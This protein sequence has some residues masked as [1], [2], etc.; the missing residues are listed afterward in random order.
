MVCSSRA[1]AYYTYSPYLMLTV[2][3]GPPTTA[4][5]GAP[6]RRPRP[7]G[8][9]PDAHSQVPETSDADLPPGPGGREAGIGLVATVGPDAG[10]RRDG[11]RTPPR[12]GDQP[13]AGAARSPSGRRRPALGSP[14]R[15][16]RGDPRQRPHRP[17]SWRYGAARNHRHGAAG[18]GPVRGQLPA[19]RGRPGQPAVLGRAGDRRGGPAGE[20]GARRPSRGGLRPG[21]GGQQRELRPAAARPTDLFRRG[22]AERAGQ[23]GPRV[24]RCIGP[25]PAGPSASP[26]E[27]RQ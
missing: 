13:L 5:P 4:E 20:P 7:R 9:H 22:T 8:A 18:D 17:T 25:G 10:L 26:R 19:P 15:H 12:A 16:Q 11:D 1:L 14:V 6:A 27:G 2:R 21:P 3:T 23:P 24:S